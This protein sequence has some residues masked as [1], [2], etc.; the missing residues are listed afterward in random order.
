M[1]DVVPIEQPDN[2]AWVI[3][4]IRKLWYEGNVT[5]TP[6]VEKEMKRRK[7]LLPDIRHIIKM[8]TIVD[9]SKPGSQLEV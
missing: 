2:Y 9:H 3:R 5:W 4:R 6:H 7:L 8:G 1:G